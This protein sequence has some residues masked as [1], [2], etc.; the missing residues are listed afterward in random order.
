MVTGEETEGPD[1]VAPIRAL[2]D[3]IVRLSL[4]TTVAFAVVAGL[5]TFWSPILPMAVAVDLGMFV[6]G[7]AVMLWA[8]LKGV[9]R[10]RHEVVSL[11]ALFFLA[12][13]AAPRRIALRLWAC[14][15]VQVVVAVVT[16][17]VRPYSSLAF[18][19]LAPV[20]GLAM[21]SLWGAVHGTFP[22]R[23]DADG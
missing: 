15:V 20:L 1:D 16:A 18:G 11:A 19:I 10:S 9:D 7:A 2:D 8:F 13:G 17:L 14:L 12:E 6:V 22:R 23:P 5:G 21:L 4:W 3:R